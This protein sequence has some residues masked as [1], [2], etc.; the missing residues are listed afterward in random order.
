[1]IPDGILLL[2]GGKGHAVEQVRTLVGKVTG[3]S[4]TAVYHSALGWKLAVPLEE[5]IRRTWQWLVSR[6]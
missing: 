5:G 3:R 6:A 1:M 2:G 4:L